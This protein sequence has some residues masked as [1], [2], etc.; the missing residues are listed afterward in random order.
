MAEIKKRK[1]AETWKKKEWYHV[2]S[3][4]MFD[5]REVGTTPADEEIKL[6]NR[7]VQV[8]LR[9][10]TGNMT[11]QFTKLWFKVN[12][13]KGKNALTEFHGFEL[14]R[15]YL[16]RNVRRRRSTILVVEDS[17]TTDGKKVQLSVYAFTMRKVDTSKKHLITNALIESTQK[18]IKQNSLEN[19]AKSLLFGP[20]ASDLMKS[21]KHIAPIKR[22]EIGKCEL[23][24]EKDK[25]TAGPGMEAASGG[26][27]EP[28]SL[29]T[30]E[31]PQAPEQ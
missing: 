25:K 20:A 6:K 14:M 17:K 18:L 12:D 2:I 13:I 26:A 1:T 15:E 19:L 16:R 11:H 21:V 27:S 10:I 3:P 8:P 24:P 4:R 23:L 29:L 22:I 7:V 5:E 31:A 28:E 9:D 30:L